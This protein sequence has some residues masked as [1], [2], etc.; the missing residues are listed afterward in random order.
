MIGAS[1][2]GFQAFST[3]LESLPPDIPAAI[4]FILHQRED[5]P[6]QVAAAVRRVTRLPVAIAGEGTRLR[7]GWIYVPSPGKSLSFRGH[8]VRE[9]RAEQG[10]YFTSI[11]RMF[12]SAAASY[13]DRVIGIVLTGLLTDGTEGLKA[14]H[15]AG[16]LTIVQNPSDAEYPSMPRSAMKDLPV[17]FCLDLP[18]IGL[19]LDLLARRSR[20]LESGIAIS[21]RTLKKR[22]ELLVRLKEQSGGN[23]GSFDFLGEELDVLKRDLDSIHRLLQK[24]KRKANGKNQ[25]AQPPS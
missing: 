19:A 2:G 9:S 5:S 7:H 16:G 15:D 13:G 6:Y 20:R 17:T 18:D 21:I 24:V 10:K 4:V 3:I 8:E 14:I 23:V 12:S 22:V 11:N 1:A 25:P